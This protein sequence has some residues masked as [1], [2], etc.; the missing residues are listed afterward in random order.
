MSKAYTVHMHSKSFHDSVS[1][2]V[3][4]FERDDE[5]RHKSAGFEIYERMSTARPWWYWSHK[6]GESEPR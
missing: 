3:F 6:E 4:I 1:G 5:R 2:F